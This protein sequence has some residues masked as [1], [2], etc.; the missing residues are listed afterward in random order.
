MFTLNQTH[1]LVSAENILVAETTSL[2]VLEGNTCERVLGVVHLTVHVV[3]FVHKEVW[4]GQWVGHQQ[5]DL[6][7]GQFHTQ[8]MLLNKQSCEGCIGDLGWQS[9]LRQQLL[10]CVLHTLSGQLLLRSAF[11]FQMFRITDEV[12]SFH[13]IYIINS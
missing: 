6:S 10:D 2:V 9:Q 8:L 4:A 1:R 12:C 13:K 5:L 7:S 11:Y 3:A